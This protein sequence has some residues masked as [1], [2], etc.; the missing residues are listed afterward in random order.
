MVKSKKRREGKIMKEI[1][2][3]IRSIKAEE[4]IRVIEEAG[5]PGLTAIEVQ[6]LG[7]GIDLDK[8]EFSMQYAEKVCTTTKVE[9][10]CNDADLER[11][12]N[13]IREKAC[14]KH[15][16]DGIIFVSD[17]SDAIKISTGVS[18]ENALNSIYEAK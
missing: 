2:A 3:Y 17:I 12:V 13:I 6:T 16:G 8:A 15:K 11:L 10:V 4:V 9:V 18:G 1:K 7:A 5:A 14:S